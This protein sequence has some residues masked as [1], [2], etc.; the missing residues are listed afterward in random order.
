MPFTYQ[1]KEQ[2]QKSNTILR[3]QFWEKYLLK[4]R[5]RLDVCHYRITRAALSCRVAGNR[6]SKVEEI[7][8]ELT[9]PKNGAEVTM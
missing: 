9:Y 2:E 8:H 3:D 1:P 5:Q 6:N 4:N 7:S